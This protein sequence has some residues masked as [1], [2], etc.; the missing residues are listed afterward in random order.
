[1][2]KKIQNQDFLGPIRPE[3][4]LVGPKLLLQKNSIGTMYITCAH[5]FIDAKSLPKFGGHLV[6]KPEGFWLD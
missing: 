4:Q 2:A 5:V 1:M 3:G 6:R